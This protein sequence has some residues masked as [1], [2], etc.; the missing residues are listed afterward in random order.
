MRSGC[1][2][3]I[4][5]ALLFLLST[6]FA[7]A[8]EQLAQAAAA[9]PQK[10]TLQF[11]GVDIMEILKLLA[12]QAGFNLVAGKNVSGR[13]T[14]FVKEVDPWEALEV[15]LAANELA[16]ERKGQILT[17][18][19]QRDYE[20]LHGQPYQDRRILKSIVPRYAKAA[21]LSRALVQVKS[22]IGRV[23]ADESTNTLILMDT[24]SLVEQM[25]NL[26]REMDQPLETRIFSL[27]Y[28]TV[29]ALNPILQDTLTKGVGKISV[30][31]RTNQVAVTDYPVKLEGLA[32]VIQAFDE[33]ATEV[34]IDATIV[35][36]ALSDKFQLGIDWETLA[37]ENINLKGMG[38]LNLTSG[39]ALKI[40]QASISKGG[41]Y[42]V[43]IEALRTFGE[44]RILSEPRLTVVN[45]QEAKIL[46]GS[47]EPYVTTAVSQTGTGTAVTS[48]SVTFLDVG[49]KLFVTPTIT[50]DRFV[51]M[52]VRPEVSSKTGTLT[53]SQKNEIPIV[54]TAE[55][56]TVL[57]VEDGGTVIL[58]GLIKEEKS[59]DQQRIPVLSDVP[60][61]GI[62]FRSHKETTKRTELVVL[63]NPRIITGHRIDLAGAS[64]AAGE[65]AKGLGQLDQDRYDAVIQNLVQR[66]ARVQASLAQVK[67]KAVVELTLTPDGH[68]QGDPRIVEAQPQDLKPQAKQAVLVA[69][70]SFPP[71]PSSSEKEPRTLVVSLTYE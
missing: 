18:M 26:I 38:A 12:E 13:V 23:V 47:K 45:N 9:P 10:V 25:L 48:E 20:L 33:R 2:V 51:L 58:G 19:T 50:R 17:I 37:R 8:E 28:G 56:E 35:Q 40:A 65:S 64:Q 41:D 1:R 11:Q 62:L 27:N 69:S 31:E 7:Q 68:L 44:T 46:V 71:F 54:E 52:K 43:L 15:I 5:A 34:R 30:D 22:N 21:D 39:G 24:P 70:S 32:K 53:T 63:L 36:V 57:L 59:V 60:L 61:L 29:K 14:L 49:I 66:V 6:S 55:A 67:G 16:Y 3:W 42:K 4:T